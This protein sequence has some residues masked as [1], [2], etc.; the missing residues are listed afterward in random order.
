MQIPPCRH[1]RADSFVQALTC[2]HLRADTTQGTENIPKAPPEHVQNSSRALLRV[3]FEPTLV[4]CMALRPPSPGNPGSTPYIKK[5]MTNHVEPGNGG[6][7]HCKTDGSNNTFCTTPVAHTTARY[8]AR[9]EIRVTKHWVNL[10]SHC[11]IHY[12]QQSTT[13]HPY[14]CYM[15]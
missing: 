1:L 4:Q 15:T 14:R 5:L 12:Q 10:G 11:L 7:K 2:R 3:Q 9:S 13:K 8:L 6:V